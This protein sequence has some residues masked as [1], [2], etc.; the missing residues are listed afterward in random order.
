MVVKPSCPHHG[1]VV[2][3]IEGQPN[4]VKVACSD[5]P[6]FIIM[7]YPS[8]PNPSRKR[9]EPYAYRENAG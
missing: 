1:V 4:K 3:A 9:I 7:T 2:S 5:C 6:Q 8:R